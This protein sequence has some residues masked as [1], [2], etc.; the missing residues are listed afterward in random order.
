[1]WNPTSSNQED[2]KFD[3]RKIHH[4]PNLPNFSD[5]LKIQSDLEKKNDLF[6]QVDLLHTSEKYL[7]KYKELKQK[8]IAFGLEWICWFSQKVHL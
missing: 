4:L 8:N 7:C 3:I 5:F 2:A 1:M 6:L